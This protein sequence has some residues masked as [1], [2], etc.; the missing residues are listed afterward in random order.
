MGTS[1]RRKCFDITLFDD[2]TVE[3][4][5]SFMVIL[6]AN[7]NSTGIPVVDPDV[8]EVFILD[9]DRKLPNNSYRSLVHTY[10]APLHTLK[11]YNPAKE[12]SCIEV[13]GAVMG[14]EGN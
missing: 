3:N 6:V 9:N 10:G 8:T 2:D 7:E 14:G 4:T 12:T 5:E 11:L 1:I 13:G